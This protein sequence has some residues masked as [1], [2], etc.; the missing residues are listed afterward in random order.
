MSKIWG[1]S[2]NKK[3]FLTKKKKKKDSPVSSGSGTVS[4]MLVCS[5]EVVWQL[6][7]SHKFDL[8]WLGAG[9]FGGGIFPPF[10]SEIC[11]C[12]IKT[13]LIS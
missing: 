6:S 3:H 2:C 8:F 9:T 10:L 11:C 5:V 4:G 12:Q 13:N 7:L 1:S